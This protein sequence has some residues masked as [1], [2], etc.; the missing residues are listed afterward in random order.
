[1]D[2]FVASRLAMTGLAAGVW[3]DER[4]IPGSMRRIAPE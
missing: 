2:C 3:V 4:E 1:M